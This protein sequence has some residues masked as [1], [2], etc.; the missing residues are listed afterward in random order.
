MIK[1]WSMS[2]MLMQK[3]ASL[4]ADSPGNE[5]CMTPVGFHLEFFG[6]S[7]KERR[8]LKKHD[9]EGRMKLHFFEGE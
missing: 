1:H 4:R 5:H 2:V 7:L 3:N 9:Y 6:L 8:M